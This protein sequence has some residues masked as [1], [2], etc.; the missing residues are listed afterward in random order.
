LSQSKAS[1]IG[2]NDVKMNKKTSVIGKTF[3]L[4]IQYPGNSNVKPLHRQ[5]I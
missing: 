1:T 4:V 2:D 3:R 5:N